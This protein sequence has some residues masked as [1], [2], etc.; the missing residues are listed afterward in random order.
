ML[1]HLFLCMVNIEI[2]QVNIFSFQINKQS[3]TTPHFFVLVLIWFREF[4]IEFLSPLQKQVVVV[5][6]TANFGWRFFAFWVTIIAGFAM[7]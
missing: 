1:Q 3:L 2:F 4:L 6:K 7:F 5:I